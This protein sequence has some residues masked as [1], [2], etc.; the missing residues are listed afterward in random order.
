L[1]TI[2]KPGIQNAQISWNE[3]VPKVRHRELE[4][5][6]RPQIGFSRQNRECGVKYV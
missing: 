3:H 2:K 6:A 4:V 5:E 1:I